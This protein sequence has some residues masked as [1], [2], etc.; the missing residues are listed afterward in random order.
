MVLSIVLLHAIGQTDTSG[1]APAPVDT[2]VAK[3]A[4]KS[5][6]SASLGFLS[7][8]VYNG[9]KDSVATPY[10]TPMIGYFDKSGFFID[11]SLSYLARS[12][13]SRI[14][15]YNVEAGY[16]FNL[17]NFDGEIAA[18]KSFY[19]SSSTNVK[20]QIDGSVFFSGGYDFS[21]IKPSIEAGV[22]F[23]SVS[24]YMLAFGLEHTFYAAG[25]K[26]Q[27]TPSFLGNGST[28]NY[29]GSYF[30]KR[31]IGGKKKNAGIV[32]NVSAIVQDAAKFKMLD[33][34]CSIPVSYTL[35]KY[36]FSLTPVLAVPVNPAVVVTT[37]TPETGGVTRTKTAQETI[38]NSFFCSFGISY[39]F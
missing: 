35:N 33:Y 23:G 5:Y 22:N 32:Y 34:E 2:A 12:G 19:N 7:N 31:K 36:T 38:S 8:S 30:N 6:F 28:Q 13:A 20:S 16:G 26:L 21:F 3:K 1:T 18:N 29:Y 37:I 25:D 14:D 11:A 17:G 9:R 24:D 27:L 4:G 15:L 39:K 10:I